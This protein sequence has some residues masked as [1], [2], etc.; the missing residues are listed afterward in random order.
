[1]NQSH[2]DYYLDLFDRVGV[3]DA[4]MYISNAHDYYFHGVWRYP[5]HWQKLFC[6]NTPRSWTKDHPTEIFR[7]GSGDFTAENMV[8]D[9]LYRYEL[10]LEL[11]P[12]EYVQLH[13]AQGLVAP[14]AD[15]VLYR[16][17]HEAARVARRVGL[18]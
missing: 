5:A 13:G 17:R 11:T 16:I 12:K 15:A 10:S 7:S 4:T 2:V 3:A 8:A 14:M 6:S 18:K 1:M 9:A